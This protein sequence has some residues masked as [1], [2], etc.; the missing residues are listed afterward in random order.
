[1][2]GYA[3]INKDTNVLDNICSW[4]ES[5]IPE[6]YPITDTQCLLELAE[7]K[8]KEFEQ[9]ISSGKR[10]KITNNDTLEFVE[11]VEETIN[12]PTET[13]LL[14]EQVDT[15]SLQILDLMGV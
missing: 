4:G 9:V 11:F 5:H 13:E 2:V 15:L 3:F 14:Q 7:N 1:M 10:I 12:Q 8:Y 6:S